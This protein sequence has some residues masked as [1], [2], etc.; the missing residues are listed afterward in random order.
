MKPK[1]RKL[2]DCVL[3]YK[4]GQDKD[5]AFQAI[6][7]HLTHH[8][9]SLCNIIC[10]TNYNVN[11]KVFKMIYR[12][13]HSCAP[14]MAWSSFG[15]EEEDLRQQIYM[16]IL[17]LMDSYKYNKVSFLRFVT[18]L[19]PRRISA[20]IEKESKT[21]TKQYY[22]KK[23]EDGTDEMDF[24]F[25]QKEEPEEVPDRL[26]FLTDTEFQILAD[27]ISGTSIEKIKERYHMPTMEDAVQ[28][29]KE[30]EF[31]TSTVLKS[32]EDE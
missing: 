24:V 17:Q 26:S 6:L 28:R 27:Y 5:E 14:N 9:N 31:R 23:I 4:E 15:I 18:F 32:L 20:W 19:L 1:Y 3:Y 30:L 2:N 7:E 22:T 25:K 10:E 16:T 12:G 29:V 13:L 11:K 21:G 8:I